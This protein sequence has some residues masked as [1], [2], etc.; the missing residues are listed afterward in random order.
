[1]KEQAADFWPQSSMQNNVSTGLTVPSCLKDMMHASSMDRPNM[2]KIGLRIAVQGLQSYRRSTCANLRKRN[3]LLVSDPSTRSHC[4]VHIRDSG[5]LIQEKLNDS[6]NVLRN[7][8]KGTKG[9]D[10]ILCCA[11]I[12][13][14]ARREARARGLPNG[15]RRTPVF[16]SKKVDG[17]TPPHT[18]FLAKTTP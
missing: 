11:C 17:I 8:R 10:P 16:G 15:R 6:T 4:R 3:T 12:Q 13:S 7:S 9:K 5:F 18:T 1:M 2:C 14:Y